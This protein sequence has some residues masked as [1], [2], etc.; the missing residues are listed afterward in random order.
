MDAALDGQ[1]VV[2][3]R[4]SRSELFIDVWMSMWAAKVYNCL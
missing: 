1:L 4:V 3:S 2:H